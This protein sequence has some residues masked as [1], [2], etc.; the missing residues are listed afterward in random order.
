[1]KFRLTTFIA[2]TF[3][4]GLGN[5]IPSLA[6]SDLYNFQLAFTGG[7]ESE[8]WPGTSL[9]KDTLNSIILARCAD[10]ATLAQLQSLGIDNLTHR[11]DTMTTRHLIRPSE[12]GYIAAMPVIIGWKREFVDSVVNSRTRMFIPAIDSIIVVLQSS[13]AIPHEQI[14]HVLWSR[15]M[16]DNW[17]DAWQCAFHDENGPTNATW[18]MYPWHPFA[19]GTNKIQTVGDGLLYLTWGPKCSDHLSTLSNLLYEINLAA[20]KKEITDTQAVDTLK[21]LGLLDDNSLFTPFYSSGNDRVDSVLQQLSEQYIHTVANA[22]DYHAI[23]AR[24][25][26]NENDLFLILLHETAYAI[27]QYCDSIG[28]I[29]APSILWGTGDPNQIAQLVSMIRGNPPSAEDEATALFMRNNWHGS[30][31]VVHKFRKLL[32]DDPENRR[33]TLFL[34]F[35]L[36]DVRDYDGAIPVFQ[37]LEDLTAEDE[38]A[39]PLHDWSIIWAGHVYDAM[40]L[41]DKA[42]EEYR[43][44]LETP[45]TVSTYQFGQYGI[46]PINARAWA[47]DRIQ[48]PFRVK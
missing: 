21:R 39:R 32:A 4:V 29:P 8:N 41:R 31:E 34:G 27:L 38:S 33:I 15:V 47:K 10:G 44:V 12:S 23:G 16:D 22:Y 11:L 24:L 3:I 18:I 9:L 35:S 1:M 43:R 7:K 36:Y 19:V 37:K 26:I 45:D 48:E 30:P 6:Q 42:I 40:G 17:S 28:T 14:F 46:G 20:W 2:L 5:G 13:P 25:G